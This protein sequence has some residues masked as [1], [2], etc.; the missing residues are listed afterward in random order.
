MKKKLKITFISAAVALMVS[1]PSVYVQSTIA[2][3]DRTY[4]REV[5][6]RIKY[7]EFGNQVLD[8]FLYMQ[9]KLNISPPGTHPNFTTKFNKP[10][11]ITS[12]YFQDLKPDVIKLQV[13]L[14]KID[15]M[16]TKN[17]NF[18]KNQNIE[19]Q[20]KSANIN[21]ANSLI[22]ELNINRENLSKKIQL[23]SKTYTSIE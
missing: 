1:I 4:E 9:I 14:Q 16:I 10:A 23:Y 3:K 5:Y 22:R 20:L 12:I 17:V 19:A 6:K 21:E 11:F 13:I 8:L 2:K 15:N 7:E 18:E